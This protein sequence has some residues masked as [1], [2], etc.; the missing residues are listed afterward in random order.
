MSWWL[1]R[2]F[3]PLTGLLAIAA[4]LSLGTLSVRR[5]AAV[6][7]VMAVFVAPA[8]TEIR[9][10]WSRGFDFRQ[11]SGIIDARWQSGDA[12]ASK[13]VYDVSLVQTALQYYTGDS[14][15]FLDPPASGGRVWVID[16]SQAC[17]PLQSWDL[18]AG[19]TLELCD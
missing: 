15:R 12:I 13:S 8:Y 6:F 3:L 19:H 14:S 2:S 1:G 5:C 11:A 16:Q 4:G 10:P 9:L 17:T 7:A 18:G